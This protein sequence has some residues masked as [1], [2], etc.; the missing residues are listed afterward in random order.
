ME[1]TLTTPEPPQPQV[2]PRRQQH[3]RRRVTTGRRQQ[4]NH[5]LGFHQPGPSA[6]EM[7][8][9]RA[10]EKKTMLAQEEI[11]KSASTLIQTG[12]GK[13]A[14]SENQRK[15]FREEIENSVAIPELLKDHLDFFYRLSSL[16]QL[17]GLVGQKY[18]KS[19]HE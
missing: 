11:Q 4:Q 19:M 17:G 2:H 7:M 1:V 13:F 14:R 12:M 16:V 5:Q 18:L 9:M 3:P 10:Q 8:A 15:R 6:V